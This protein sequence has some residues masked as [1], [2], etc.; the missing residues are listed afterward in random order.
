MH[1]GVQE[2][3]INRNALIIPGPGAMCQSKL[4][5]REMQHTFP[6]DRTVILGRIQARP[7][8]AGME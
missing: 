4:D 1:T 6:V 2:F 7:K 8:N 5:F 3:A